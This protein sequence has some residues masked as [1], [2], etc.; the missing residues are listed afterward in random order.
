M[1]LIAVWNC[2]DMVRLI[3]ILCI[4]IN[5]FFDTGMTLIKFKV[6]FFECVYHIY[7]NHMFITNL[8]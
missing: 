5:L 3:Y 4:L 1:T 2:H 6:S 7:S 8:Y